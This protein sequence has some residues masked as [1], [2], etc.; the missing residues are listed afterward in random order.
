[1]A[2]AKTEVAEFWESLENMFDRKIPIDPQV[3]FVINEG[4]KESRNLDPEKREEVINAAVYLAHDIVTSAFRYESEAEV[5]FKAM[6]TAKDFIHKELTAE[7]ITVPSDE[8]TES[9]SE[10]K[11][12]TEDKI[13]PGNFLEQFPLVKKLERKSGL[14]SVVI[15]DVINIQLNIIEKFVEENKETIFKGYDYETLKKKG[16]YNLHPGTG[17]PTSSRLRHLSWNRTPPKLE[18]INEI[19]KLSLSSGETS[20]K[21]NEAF[22]R[23]RD[24]LLKKAVESMLYAFEEFRSKLKSTTDDREEVRNQLLKD[25]KIEQLGKEIKDIIYPR[26][27]SDGVFVDSQA[28]SLWERGG[29]DREKFDDFGEKVKEMF[30]K[31]PKFVVFWGEWAYNISMKLDRAASPSKKNTKTTP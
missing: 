1:M 11:Q 4:I 7:K 16:G 29:G 2:S 27:K 26:G 9:K 3:R 5:A 31:L 12:T 24:E 25:T 21:C 8:E 19:L 14:K 17:L 23:A 20:R 13:S 15:K 22:S 30:Q 6:E 10:T 28:L 18:K